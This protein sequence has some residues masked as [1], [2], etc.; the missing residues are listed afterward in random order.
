MYAS[1]SMSLRRSALQRLDQVG[2]GA[3]ALLPATSTT[4]RDSFKQLS[5]RRPDHFRRS[6]ALLRKA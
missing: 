4:V 6:A 1:N 3:V 5:R 2:G